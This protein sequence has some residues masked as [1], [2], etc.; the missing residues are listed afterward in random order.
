VRAYN[1]GNKEIVSD[2]QGADMR[3]EFFHTHTVR[4]DEC[5]CN[6]VLTPPAFLRYMQDIA[7]LDAE[8]A[9]LSGNGYWVVK[10]TFI[11]FASPITIH[12][13]LAL[14]TYGLGFSRVTA[15]RGY[16]AR[17]ADEPQSEPII[18]AHTL[19]VYVDPHGRPTRMPERTAQIW[20]PDGPL[21]PQSDE[22]FP[23]TPAGTP[24]T[25]TSTVRFSEIDP[26]RHL[27]NASAVEMLDNAAWGA[28]ASAGI[29]PDTARFDPLHYDIEYVDSPLFGDEL[30]VQSW[31]HPLP[32]VGQECVRHQQITR[33]GKVMVR[34]HSRWLWRA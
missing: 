2:I 25:T 13:R 10:R 9:Q 20:L 5:D 14:K 23:I 6:G 1:W 11:T 18:A 29:T 8:D 15:Q 4:Y 32:T 31:L 16:E 34:A 12:A 27:N 21:A 7:A 26:M 28:Y 19:W 33:A 24:A 22:P 3:R 30:T 17:L